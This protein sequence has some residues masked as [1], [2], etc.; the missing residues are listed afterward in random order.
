MCAIHLRVMELEGNSEYCLEEASFVLSP[1][2][3]GIVE[4]ATIHADCA[5]NF[6]LRQSRSADDH[7]VD[8]VVIGTTLCHLFRE[9]KVT[10][11][12]VR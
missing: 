9:S 8:Q 11:I 2:E 5:I 3:E 7:T 1:N 4:D 6:V 10:L 12:K